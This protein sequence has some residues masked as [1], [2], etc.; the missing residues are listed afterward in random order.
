MARELPAVKLPE[1][2]RIRS[3]QV[4]AKGLS[5][6]MAP[7]HPLGDPIALGRQDVACEVY[8]LE[9]GELPPAHVR[10]ETL[11]R[12]SVDVNAKGS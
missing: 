9:S 12:D 4:H 1:D 6:L 5:V 2:R 10:G 8:P 11:K 7:C 3:V